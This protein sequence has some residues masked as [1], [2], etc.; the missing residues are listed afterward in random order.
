MNYEEELR[1]KLD[2]TRPISS[3]TATVMDV[4]TQEQQILDEL[5]GEFVFSRYDLDESDILRTLKIL[6]ILKS[7][8]TAF[9]HATALQIFYILS[10][11]DVIT[12]KNLL[13]FCKLPSSEFK[14]ILNAMAKE[15]LVFK[16]SDG[17]LELS[18]DGKSLATRIG[19]DIFIWLENRDEF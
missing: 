15:N 11:I 9:K 2:A 17:E 19:V 7:Y 8:P 1:A 14:M 5:D 3:V 18:L 12:P 4:S 13:A 16:N 10:R 6:D